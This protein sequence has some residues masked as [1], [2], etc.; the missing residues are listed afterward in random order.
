[1]A[2]HIKMVYYVGILL[3][4]AMANGLTLE[5]RFEELTNNFVEMKRILAIK[6]SRLEALELK[7]EQH[8][9]DAKIKK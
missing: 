3:A 9:I 6:D 4:V 8:G 2:R 7:V 1:M 5:E